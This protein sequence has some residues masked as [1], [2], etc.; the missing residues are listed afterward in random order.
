MFT[1]ASLI[2][3]VYLSLKF[4]SNIGLVHVQVFFYYHVFWSFRSFSYVFY[5]MPVYSAPIMPFL[6]LLI[7]FYE[8]PK[9]GLH[10]CKVKKHFSFLKK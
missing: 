9:T 7:L 6:R 4:T 2:S 1:C 5:A 10:A 3:L 8:S